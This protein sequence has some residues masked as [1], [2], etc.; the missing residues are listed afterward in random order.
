[1]HP[2]PLLRVAS[3]VASIGKASYWYFVP[4][5]SCFSFKF[6]EI[7]LE[8]HTCLLLSYVTGYLIYVIVT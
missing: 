6:E 5:N 4:F 3:V 2:Y 1:M 7:F 8:L